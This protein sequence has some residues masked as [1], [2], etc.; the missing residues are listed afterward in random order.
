MRSQ[1]WRRRIP[2][3]GSELLV[4]QRSLLEE[5][6]RGNKSGKPVIQIEMK[7]VGSVRDLLFVSTLTS[8]RIP[9][10]NSEYALV[11]GRVKPRKKRT[12]SGKSY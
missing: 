7:K 10:D 11:R 12:R 4:P 2:K 5:E 9:E 3:F 6:E 1:Q 8:L